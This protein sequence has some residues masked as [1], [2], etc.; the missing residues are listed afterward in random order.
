MMTQ[1]LPIAGKL[2]IKTLVAKQLP[3]NIDIVAIDHSS[4]Y[5]TLATEVA[6]VLSKSI[7]NKPASINIIL[8]MYIS[9]IYIQCR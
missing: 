2:P 6:D 5:D 8:C 3:T 7:S 9:I 4:C 1:P